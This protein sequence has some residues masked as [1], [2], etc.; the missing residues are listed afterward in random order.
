MKMYMTLSYIFFN[1]IFIMFNDAFCFSV[2]F[3]F[4]MTNHYCNYFYFFNLNNRKV[5][6]MAFSHL[7]GNHAL[8]VR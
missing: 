4:K 8:L 1:T 6:G 5:T 7:E 2:L 3:N